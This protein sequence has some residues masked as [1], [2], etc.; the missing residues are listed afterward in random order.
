MKRFIRMKILL[1]GAL[2]QLGTDTAHHVV[3]VDAVDALDSKRPAS[4]WRCC[5]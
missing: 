4:N 2:G 1:I 3:P 5:R